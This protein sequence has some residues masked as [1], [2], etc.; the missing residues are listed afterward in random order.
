MAMNIGRAASIIVYRQNGG[1]P[2]VFL[3][4]RSRRVK[5]FPGFWVFPGGKQDAGDIAVAH[6]LPPQVFNPGFI[7]Q[8]VFQE[9]MAEE[10]QQML[11]T[12]PDLEIRPAFSDFEWLSLAVTAARELW[13]ETGMALSRPALDE[14]S[15]AAVQARLLE[16]A[17][18]LQDL[19]AQFAFALD[20]SA[21]EVAGRITTPDLGP[22]TRRFDTAF[23]MV[24]W[25]DKRVRGAL[26]KEVEAGEWLSPEEA[27]R[28]FAP[29]QLAIP[30][31]YILRTL[32]ERWAPQNMEG[33]G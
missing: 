3:T 9:A 8:P 6:S 30:T 23:F 29:E 32:H 10:F 1:R 27:L 20:L 15:S 24:P 18:G 4:R 11:G 21:V 14:A 33:R 13:E 19:L 2:E 26:S 28:Q 17:D 31:Q 12:Q 16:Q 7:F 22:H 5:S 25:P